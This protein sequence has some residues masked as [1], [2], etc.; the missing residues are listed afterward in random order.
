MLNAKGRVCY[1]GLF[2][3]ADVDKGNLN[4]L[5]QGNKLPYQDVFD[6]RNRTD[7]TL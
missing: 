5:T 1:V 2:D 7:S 6:E 4:E 3:E